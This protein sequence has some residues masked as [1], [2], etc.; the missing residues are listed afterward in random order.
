ML[1]FGNRI[2]TVLNHHEASAGCL[3]LDRGGVALTIALSE[4]GMRSQIVVLKRALASSET[5]RTFF[6]T[7]EIVEVARE[8]RTR[9]LGVSNFDLLGPKA[10]IAFIPL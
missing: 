2:K 1:E 7:R 8:G 5:V 9:F 4:S 10:H 3:A 6:T